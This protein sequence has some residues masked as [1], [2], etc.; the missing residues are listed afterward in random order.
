MKQASFSC[1]YI[2]LKTQIRRES[3]GESFEHNTSQGD[4]KSDNL[5]VLNCCLLFG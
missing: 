2:W 4:R 3:M 1:T 5:E